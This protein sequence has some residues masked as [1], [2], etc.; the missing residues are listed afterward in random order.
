V[1]SGNRELKPNVD[2]CCNMEV[3]LLAWIP[4][5]LQVRVPRCEKSE[6]LN[7]LCLRRNAAVDV[8]NEFDRFLE[9][10]SLAAEVKSRALPESLQ[11]RQI[12]CMS[13]DSSPYPHLT[14]DLFSVSLLP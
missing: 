3:S 6:F 5:G 1:L 12:T 4:K 9:V 14:C 10:I 8:C 2:S 7:R 11:H 13:G